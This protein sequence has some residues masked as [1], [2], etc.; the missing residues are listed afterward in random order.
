M[1]VRCTDYP[2]G[3]LTILEP[4]DQKIGEFH[5]ALKRR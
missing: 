1:H 5:L 2:T 4:K 3:P